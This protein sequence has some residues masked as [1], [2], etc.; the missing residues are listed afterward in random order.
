MLPDAH[1][2]V[3]LRRR[4]PMTQITIITDEMRSAIGKESE[5]VTYEVDN[6]G[7]RQFARA[8]GYTDPIFF[9]EA[10]AKSR[11][12]RGVVAPAGFLGHPVVVPGQPS[13]MSDVFRMDIPYKRILNGGTVT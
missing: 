4:S 11:G 12:Y 5:P 2:R 6:T 1:V 8:V 9:D 7:C 13:R 10:A 3:V